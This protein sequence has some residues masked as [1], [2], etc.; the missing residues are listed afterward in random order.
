M[1]ACEASLGRLGVDTIDLYQIH[2]F[3]PNTPLEETLA[4]LDQL[5]QQGKVRY[6]GASTGPAWKFAQALGLSDRYGW[7]RFVTKRA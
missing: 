6:I 1:Q 5:V 7:A 3:D 4:A 2:R